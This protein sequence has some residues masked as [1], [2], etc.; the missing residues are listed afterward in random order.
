MRRIVVAGILAAVVVVG[1][2]G[3]AWGSVIQV[4]FSSDFT[5]GEKDCAMAAV[6]EWE[7]AIQNNYTFANVYMDIG[8]DIPGA[9]AG[10]QMGFGGG[11][12]IPPLQP[13]DYSVE[14]HIELT[15]GYLSQISFDTSSAAPGMYDGLSIFLHELGHALGFSNWYDSFAAHLVTQGDGSRLYE[16]GALSVGIT[17]ESQGTHMA[18]ANYPN[19]L[20]NAGLPAGVRRP[21]SQIDL[22]ILSDAY[23]YT[24]PEPATLLLIG[25]GT[26]ALLAARRR[27]KGGAAIRRA[28]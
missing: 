10:T 20:M 15:Q 1:S 28:G 4:S 7:A 23:G 12:F 13:W 22:A 3:P 11:F 8:N 2:A 18:D 9:L 24:V 6:S 14:M 21:I 17:P 27:R 5:Q 19:D 26:A 25:V 16:D